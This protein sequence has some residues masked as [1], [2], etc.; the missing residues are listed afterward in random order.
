MMVTIRFGTKE[1]SVDL[2]VGLGYTLTRHCHKRIVEDNK[3]QIENL[4]FNEYIMIKASQTELVQSRAQCKSNQRTVM[5]ATLG[6]R[7]S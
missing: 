3:V 5:C 6:E 2:T 7:R 1:L 4:F